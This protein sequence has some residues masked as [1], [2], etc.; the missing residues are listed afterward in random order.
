MTDT[1]QINQPKPGHM[2]TILVD[3]SHEAF[4]DRGVQASANII[5]VL[6]GCAEAA[7]VGSEATLVF[8]LKDNA[9]ASYTIVKDTDGGGKQAFDS[10]VQNV[11][12]LQAR[13]RARQEQQ[14]VA[15]QAPAVP[16]EG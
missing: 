12:G 10:I 16:T 7:V 2:L 6:K 9:L 5:H 3:L 1:N 14:E 13:E 15:P 4:A 11:L 8:D